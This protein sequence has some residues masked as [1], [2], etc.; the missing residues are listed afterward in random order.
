[1]KGC[2]QMIY[3]R[4]AAVRY[5]LQYALNPNPAYIFYRGDDC[6][7]FIS[8]CLRAGGAQNDYHPTHPWWYSNGRTSICW[9]VAHSLYWYIRICSEQ[10]RFGIKALTYTLN[11]PNDYAHA[12]KGKVVPG[13]LI[14]YSDAQGRIRHSTIITAFDAAGEPLVSQHT[15]EGRNVSWRKPFAQSIFHHITGIN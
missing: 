7:N 8:Q 3:N 6:T 13:D 14:Q 10:N 9:A 1:M 5:A 12:I 11:N 2:E 4:D 15:F